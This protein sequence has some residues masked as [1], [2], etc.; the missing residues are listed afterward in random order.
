MFVSVDNFVTV[1]AVQLQFK[2]KYEI[3]ALRQR[4]YEIQECLF[5]STLVKKVWLNANKARNESTP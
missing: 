2:R 1:M 5:V 3:K 4:I